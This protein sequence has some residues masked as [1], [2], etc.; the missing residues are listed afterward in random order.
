[1]D[2]IAVVPYEYRLGTECYDFINVT[3]CLL[4]GMP[5]Y[6]PP[7]AQIGINERVLSQELN[8]EWILNVPDIYG[9]QCQPRPQWHLL[10]ITQRTSTIRDFGYP[11]SPNDGASTHVFVLDTWM[12][13]DH[14]GFTRKPVRLSTSLPPHNPSKFTGHG[15][16]VGGLVASSLFGTAR[17]TQLYSVQVLDD[18]GAG[19]YAEI[20]RGFNTA[21]QQAQQHKL[22]RVVI[23]MSIG[24]GQ[25]DVMDKLI[26]D[27]SA[28]YLIVVAAGNNNEDTGKSMPG[29]AREAFTVAAINSDNVK[30]SF[31]NWG[32]NV[33]MMAPGESILSLCPGNVWCWMSGTSMASPVVAGVAAV[34]WQ[35]HPEFTIKD[36]KAYLQHVSTKN[37]LKHQRNDTVN[38][39][40]FLEQPG[41]K[42]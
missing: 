2:Y 36:L 15:T 6:I 31:S 27:L 4:E 21:H 29:S 24:G 23:N 7:W 17:N 19:T 18:D 25:S 37:L 9:G 14:K 13:I 30:A 8:D 28:R 12:D 20:I 33:K 42:C 22:E 32:R 41:N 10:R 3:A 38:R 40:V 1:M 16:H 35:K 26:N 34:T 5:Y 39:V 11:Y